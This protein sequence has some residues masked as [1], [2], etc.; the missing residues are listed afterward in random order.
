MQ[1]S[2]LGVQRMGPWDFDKLLV[3]EGQGAPIG[4]AGLA[5]LGCTDLRHGCR[6]GTAMGAGGMGH[7]RR[8]TSG[9]AIASARCVCPE[10]ECEDVRGAGGR[11]PLI[12][13][14]IRA[15]AVELV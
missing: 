10:A 13:P 14:V 8:G 11:R 12:A 9:R 5:L 7:L 4:G 6:N 2:G 15:A 1:G 3:M